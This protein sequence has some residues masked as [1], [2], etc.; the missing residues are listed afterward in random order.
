MRVKSLSCVPMKC[1]KRFKPSIAHH[2]CV[3]KV[4]AANRLSN[5]REIAVF[6]IGFA[7]SFTSYPFGPTLACHPGF[8]EGFSGAATFA[9]ENVCCLWDKAM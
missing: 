7:I 4:Q 8:L 3:W 9:S 5:D 2:F 1:G 6:K